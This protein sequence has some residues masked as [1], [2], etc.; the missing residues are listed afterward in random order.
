MA[1]AKIRKHG[2]KPLPAFYKHNAKPPENCEY[3]I[4]RLFVIF[5]HNIR[6][7]KVRDYNLVMG[8]NCLK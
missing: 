6:F 5:E 1:P 8:G 3:G 7:L 4:K 2:I